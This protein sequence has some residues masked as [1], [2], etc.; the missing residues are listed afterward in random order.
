VLIAGGEEF[1]TK[2]LSSA[3]LYD[4]STGEFTATGSRAIPRT[5]HKATMLADGKVLIVGGMVSGP[6]PENRR[7]SLISAELYDPSTGAFTP[8]GAMTTEAAFNL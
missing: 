5:G 7:F 6:P 2:P 3:E 4:P 8:T 1:R